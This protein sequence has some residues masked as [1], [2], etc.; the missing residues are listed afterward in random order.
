MFFFCT[1]NSKQTNFPTLT[2]GS[3]LWEQTQKKHQATAEDSK[4]PSSLFFNLGWSGCFFWVRCGNPFLGGK[5]WDVR[6]ETSP[7]RSGGCSQKFHSV[8]NPCLQSWCSHEKTRKST[9]DCKRPN[10]LCQGAP[11]V[12]SI[13]LA[14]FG[15][16]KSMFDQNLGCL[17]N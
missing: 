5:T 6:W 13:Q 3:L 1:R 17:P 16:C 4:F 11:K 2:S 10:L 9:Y 12:S 14:L 8:K 7:W 15:S